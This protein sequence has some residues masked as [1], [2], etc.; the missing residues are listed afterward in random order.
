MCSR[1]TDSMFV[2]MYSMCMGAGSCACNVRI[3][4][5]TYST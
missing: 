4:V 1:E 3:N 5:L 2:P